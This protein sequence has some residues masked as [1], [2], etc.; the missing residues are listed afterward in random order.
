[1]TSNLND[2]DEL[3]NKHYNETS[4]G[5][6]DASPSRLTTGQGTEKNFYILKIDLAGSTRMFQARHSSTYLKFSHTYLSTLDKIT[7]DYGADPAQ[8]EYA[9]DS[10]L[11]YFPENVPAENVLVAA[12]L[13]R[14]AVIRIAKLP[15]VVGNLNPKCKAVL[16][17]AP[18][19]VAKIGP[20]ASSFISA[21]GQPIHKVAYIEKEISVDIG[22]AT[23]EF[24][25][26]LKQINRK[27]LSE[28]C[29]ERLVEIPS[30]QLPV[31]N[32]YI[33]NTN[34][35]ADILMSI[36]APVVTPP[37]QY[38]REKTIHGYNLNWGL[39]NRELGLAQFA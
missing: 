39:L 12:C 30:F 9:G 36:S 23:I 25:K 29:T 3:L 11:A 34:R 33:S 5:L 28:Q 35:I 10:V 27:F 8:T 13:C 21:I 32:N 2:I 6:V 17:Y 4:D 24:Y 22:R 31:F 14:M 26:Q 19:I 38:R 7:Q 1:M 20:R 18:L 16:H 15:G 37:P